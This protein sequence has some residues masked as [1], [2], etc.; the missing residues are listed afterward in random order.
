MIMKRILSVLLL[1][2]VTTI[3]F[4]VCYWGTSC[5]SGT[6]GCIDESCGLGCTITSYSANYSICYTSGSAQCCICVW[7]NFTCDCAFGT[8]YGREA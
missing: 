5:F 1:A 6:D 2:S 8:G 7:Y 4:A 3:A